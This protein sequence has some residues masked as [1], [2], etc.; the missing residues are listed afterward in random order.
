MKVILVNEI[1]V[2]FFV[3]TGLKSLKNEYLR[4]VT[5]R[6]CMQVLDITFKKLHYL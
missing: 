2:V 6:K 1:K 3:F 5:I 4:H